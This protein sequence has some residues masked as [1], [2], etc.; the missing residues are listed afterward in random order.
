MSWGKPTVDRGMSNSDL[1][2]QVYYEGRTYFKSKM[3]AKQ[4]KKMYRKWEKVV[5]MSKDWY[6]RG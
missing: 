1:T 6:E 4:S 3:E 2:M 5:Q